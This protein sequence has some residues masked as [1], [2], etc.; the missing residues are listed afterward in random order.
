MA[1]SSILILFLSAPRPL[2]GA[3]GDYDDFYEGYG[4]FMIVRTTLSKH[5]TSQGVGI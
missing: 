3:I 5:I 4:P 2:D 1:T